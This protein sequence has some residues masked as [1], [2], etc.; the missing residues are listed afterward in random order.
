MKVKALKSFAGIISMAKGEVKEISNKELISDLLQ[1][2][3]IEEVKVKGTSK[4][5][6]KKASKEDK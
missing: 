6:L 2:K 4:E 3:Y 5:A 1:A